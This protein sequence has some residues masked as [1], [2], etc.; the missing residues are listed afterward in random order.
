MLRSF[1]EKRT[2][3]Q[4]ETRDDLQGLL[5]VNDEIACPFLLP[6]PVT[7]HLTLIVFGSALF[8]RDRDVNWP[9]WK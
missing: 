7:N 8:D 5:H 9:A 2:T 4:R 3:K 6:H 1:T